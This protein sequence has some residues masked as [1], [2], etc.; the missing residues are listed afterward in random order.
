[1]SSWPCG[2][3]RFHGGRAGIAGELRATVS[4]QREEE[5]DSSMRLVSSICGLLWDDLSTQ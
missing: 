5:N 3:S 4:V 1:M 2:S